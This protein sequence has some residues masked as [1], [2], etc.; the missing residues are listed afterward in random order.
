MICARQS[1]NSREILMD[2]KVINFGP[3]EILIASLTRQVAAFL[4][5]GN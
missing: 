1:G 4:A 3:N 2:L 5:K